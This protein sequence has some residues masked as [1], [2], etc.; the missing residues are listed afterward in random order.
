[1]EATLDGFMT[2][3][4]IRQA[5][6]RG[7]LMSD[8]QAICHATGAFVVLPPP[9]GVELAPLPWQRESAPASTFLKK[10]DLDLK[11][12]AVMSAANRAMKSSASTPSFIECFWD[13]MPKQVTGGASCRVKIGLQ[14]GNR[15]GHV[16]GGI[17]LGIA[18]ATAC[19][20]VPS[21]PKVSNISAWYVSPGSGKA[22][23]ARSRVIHVGRS[24]AVV[25]TE[26]KNAD[27]SRVLEAVSNHTASGG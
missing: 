20:A 11:E 21:H 23:K 17:L 6:T 25:R 9:P 2:G 1:M 12:R 8:G 24:F 27:G 19:A 18:Q 26:L 13:I 16:Q 4:G 22:L 14:I 10:S 3:H 15:V 7:V 5:Y